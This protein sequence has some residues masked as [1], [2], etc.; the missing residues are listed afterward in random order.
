ME[1][2]NDDIEILIETLEQTSILFASI[3]ARFEDEELRR[4][5][6]PDE[7]SPRELLA[8]LHACAEVWGKDIDRM[9]AQDAPSYRNVHARKVMLLD[10]HVTPTF[11]EATRAFATLRTTFL[12]TIRS[13]RPDQWERSAVIDRR[14]STVYLHVKRMASHEVVHRAQIEAA[15]NSV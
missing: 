11:E 10:R 1:S 13:L 15:V 7:W 12:E 4:R 3:A 2:T 9:L 5:P 14:P 8:H 6:S